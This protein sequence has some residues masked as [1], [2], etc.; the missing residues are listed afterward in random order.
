MHLIIVESPTKAKTIQN[1]L[2]DDYVVRSSYG[3]V[4]DL[5]KGDLG[6]DVE[7]NFEPKLKKN[8][9]DI[10]I[11]KTNGKFYKVYF[12]RKKEAWMFES[13]SGR[14]TQLLVKWKS[15]FFQDTLK[16]Q[17]IRFFL[18]DCH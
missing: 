4:R 1:F 18:N 9:E 13:N 8:W 11:R 12:N 6:V 5:P 17:K 2:P 10:I 15:Y 16:H 3:H 7:N 14:D